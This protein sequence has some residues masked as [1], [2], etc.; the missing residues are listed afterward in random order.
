MT[1]SVE[2]A[3]ARCEEITRR[4]AKNFSYGI[5]LLPTPKRQAMSALYAL[6]RRID[7]IGDGDAPADEKLAALDAVRAAIDGPPPSDDPVLVGV[8]DAARRYPIPI[9]AFGELIDGCERDARGASYATFDETVAYCRSVAGSIGRLSL[10]VFGSSDPDA[11]QLADAL[12]I[13]LQLTNILRDI[14]TDRDDLGRVYLPAEDLERFGC[15]LDLS[16]PVDAIAALVAFE[17]QRAEAYFDTG[18]GLLGLLDRRSRACVAAMAGIYHRLLRRIEA[19][20]S[21]VTTT[22]VSVPVWEKL[23]VAGR[24]LAVG[25]V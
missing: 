25:T 8:A 15:A 17:A 13:G 21:A 7:D 2:T 12:G 23:A 16:G 6:A 3:Y 14:A 9:A 20:P 1:V 4:E 10:G 5:R 22:R 24:S 19:A 11:P 18:L